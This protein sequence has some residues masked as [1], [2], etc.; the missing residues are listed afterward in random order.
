MTG[1]LEKYRVDGSRGLGYI[2]V[3]AWGETG[4]K[5][6]VAFEYS[7]NRPTDLELQEMAKRGIEVRPR[8]PASDQ[9]MS[10]LT[11]R[12]SSVPLTNGAT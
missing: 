1:S 2:E 7:K 3:Q 4:P 5:T 12:T 9:T 11:L 10:P 8:K 6:I